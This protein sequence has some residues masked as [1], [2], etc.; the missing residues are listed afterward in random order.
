MIYTDGSKG[1]NKTG[2]AYVVNGH[3]YRVRLTKYTSIFSA[4][5]YAVLLAIKHISRSRKTKFVIFCDS[6]SVLESIK[7]NN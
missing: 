1:N 2:C 7:S 6:L 5:L 3:A 4:E